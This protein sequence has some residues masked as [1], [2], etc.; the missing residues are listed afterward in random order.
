[1]YPLRAGHKNGRGDKVQQ[2]TKVQEKKKE[3]K[4]VKFYLHLTKHSASEMY[5]REWI[6]IYIHVL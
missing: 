6:Y 1:M 3:V 4:E 5:M 2:K